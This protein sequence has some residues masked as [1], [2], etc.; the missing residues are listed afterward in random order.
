LWKKSGATALVS[1]GAIVSSQL[2]CDKV[3]RVV[4]EAVY[5]ANKDSKSI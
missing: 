1:F 4:K 3:H 5:E 2:L